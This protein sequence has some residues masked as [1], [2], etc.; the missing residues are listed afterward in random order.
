MN[1]SPTRDIV[2]LI[3]EIQPDSILLL[4]TATQQV[5]ADY[6]KIS[7]AKLTHI[8]RS[9]NIIESIETAG[10]HDIAVVSNTLET[11]DQNTAG[12][13]IARLRDLYCHRLLVLMPLNIESADNDHNSPAKWQ[14]VDLLAFGL[15]KLTQY[16]NNICL[17]EYNILNYK[18]VPDWL[19]AK[20]WANPELWNKYR[21]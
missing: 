20:N 18:S 21:W 8:N 1:T 5:P 11:L 10:M 9:N 16:P 2:E 14:T 13:I 6:D 3:E 12:S 17:Y 4:D 15:T 7:N 19:N